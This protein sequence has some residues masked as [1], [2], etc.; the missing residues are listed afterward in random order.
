MKKNKGKD[1]HARE[2]HDETCLC[3]RCRGRL[4]ARLITKQDIKVK[5]GRILSYKDYVPTDEDD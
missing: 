3:R 1:D 5:P 2:K 4:A